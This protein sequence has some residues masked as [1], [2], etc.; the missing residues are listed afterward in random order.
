MKRFSYAL[1]QA[2]S[3]IHRN[4]NMSTAS[5]LAITAMLAI[6]GIFFILMV[7]VNMMTANVEEQFDCVEIYLTDSMTEADGAALTEQIGGL[8]DV[9]SA[10][11][12]SKADALEVMKTRW[13]DNAYLLDGL[14]SNPFPATIEVKATDIEK[15]AAMVEAIKT[16]ENPGIEEIKYYQEEI[17]KIIKISE[18]IETGAIILIVVLILISML[19]VS[20]TI[21]ITVHAREDEILIMKY[22]G[23]T[24]WFVRAPFLIEGIVIG[25]IASVLSTAIVGFAYYK[26]I[27]FFTPKF[28]AFFNS[29]LVPLEFIIYNLAIIFAALGICIG[30]LGSI[31]SMRKFLSA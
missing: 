5:I 26:C 30:A 3:Q 17:D 21:K 14:V 19:V 23:A 6:L 27:D 18:Y 9:A 11:Y 29:G 25:F 15:E 10:I 20:N 1:K 28:L 24:N 4:R 7:N 31:L 16:I 8:P 13:G 12:L 2:F 22:V